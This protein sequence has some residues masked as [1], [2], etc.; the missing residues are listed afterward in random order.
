VPKDF[1]KKTVRS[2]EDIKLV[3]TKRSSTGTYKW[4]RFNPKKYTF[5]VV[6]GKTGQTYTMPYSS[7]SE[8][9]VDVGFTFY[10]CEPDS[11]TSQRDFFKLVKLPG[12]DTATGKPKTYYTGESLKHKTPVSNW[13]KLSIM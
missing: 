8:N 11:S 3:C 10:K 7:M 5:E 6:S 13:Y 1:V 4:Y 12:Q 9:N 2:G